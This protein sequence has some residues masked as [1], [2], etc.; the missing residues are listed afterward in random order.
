M[1]IKFFPN[2]L[3]FPN[4]SVSFKVGLTIIKARKFS[5]VCGSNWKIWIYYVDIQ[6]LFTVMLP[7]DHLTSH[8]RMSSSRWVIPSL[9][10]S[11]SW[12]SFLYSST[13]YPC[14]L[15]LISSAYVR[16]TPFLAFIVPI[17]TW[18]DFPGGS[19]VKRLPTMQETQVQSLGRED[20]LEKEMATHSSTLA[21]KI[22]WMEEPGGPQSKGLQRVGHDWVTSLHFTWNVPLVSLIFLK[23]SLVFSILL[24]SSIS[25]HWSLRKAFWS[26]VSILWNSAFK[27]VYLSF[28]PLPFASLLFSAIYKASS[29]N[30][31]G[32]LHRQKLVEVMEFQL[33]YFKS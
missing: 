1:N 7:K 11:G 19:D 8:S 2:T 4:I 5:L 9:W 6:Y 21:W 29:D 14:H 28:Y 30:H 23:R 20:L 10:L 22:P 16:S 31:F 32:S 12:R 18:N 26:L 13:V 33:S 3:A 25:L 15:F 24:F 27:W 17:F